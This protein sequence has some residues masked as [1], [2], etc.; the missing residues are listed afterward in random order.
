MEQE[1]AYNTT[2][3]EEIRSISLPGYTTIWL[4]VVAGHM[5]LGK[6]DRGDILVWVV[7]D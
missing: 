4:G 5:S 1:V 7:E 2:L 6:F 3:L